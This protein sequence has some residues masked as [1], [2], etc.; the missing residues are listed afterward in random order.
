MVFQLHLDTEKVEHIDLS[1]P[2]CVSPEVSVRAVL[3]TLKET[4]RSNVLICRDG[5]LIGIYTE[6]D[7]LRMMAAQADID[8]P[9]E[10]SM[11][12]NPVSIQ[13]QDTVQAAIK[14]MASGGYRRL[15][16]VDADNRPVG[17][18]K[19]TA[20]LHYIVQHFPQYVYNLPP[21]SDHTTKQ[22]EGA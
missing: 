1:E 19:V 18:L 8:G 17:L 9:I 7:A 21:S 14:R 3:E 5:K 2:L 22:R 10:K 11:S 16:V 12:C 13:A 20:I 6:R 15:P 4:R